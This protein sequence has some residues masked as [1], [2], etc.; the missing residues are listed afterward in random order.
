MGGFD[1]RRTHALPGGSAWR[2]IITP[3]DTCK[4]VLQTDG[5]KGM[6]I[7]KDKVREGGL[8]VLWRPMGS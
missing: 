8:G 4:T 5:S 6:R 3:I 2:A 7:L 1:R